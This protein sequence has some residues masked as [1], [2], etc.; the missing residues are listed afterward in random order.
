M[1]QKTRAAIIGVGV[2]LS[3]EKK[4]LMLKGRS[5]EHWTFVGGKV[6]VNETPQETCIREVSEEIGIALTD[7]QLEDVFFRWNWADADILVGIL[8][9]ATLPAIPEMIVAKENEIDEYAW[10][11]EENLDRFNIPND[12]R[13]VLRRYFRK[14]NPSYK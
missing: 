13:T 1:S 4:V 14:I 8:Y 5:G 7:I 10:V 11:S 12:Q 6:E 9:S 2:I 3:A